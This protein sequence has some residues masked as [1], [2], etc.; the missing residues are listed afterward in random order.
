M[1]YCVA[2]DFIIYSLIFNIFAN[3]WSLYFGCNWFSNMLILDLNWF[4][5]SSVDLSDRF[6]PIFI[7]NS[8]FKYIFAYCARVSK[9]FSV[10][11]STF[12]FTLLM[13]TTNSHTHSQVW[14]ICKL[15][16]IFIFLIHFYIHVFF[17]FFFASVLSRRLW[18]CFSLSL[19]LARVRRTRVSGSGNGNCNG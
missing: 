15:F 14:A 11:D 17:L 2:G 16:S 3:I 9:K 6:P 18:L 7:W 12:H 19:S 8:K 4:R 13:I 5:C 1:I 10:D